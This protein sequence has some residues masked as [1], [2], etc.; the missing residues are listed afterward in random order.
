[1]EMQA[2]RGM[3]LMVAGKPFWL[4]CEE[5]VGACAAAEK[6]AAQGLYAMAAADGLDAYVTDDSGMQTTPCFWSD[7]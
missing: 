3:H 1:M 5:Y 4:A 2:W 6:G 7:L